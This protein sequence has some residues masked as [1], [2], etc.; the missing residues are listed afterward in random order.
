[1]PVNPFVQYEETL[2]IRGTY[3]YA[4]KLAAVSVI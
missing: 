1:M 2:L 3:S 4:L